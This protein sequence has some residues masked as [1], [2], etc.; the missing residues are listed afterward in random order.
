MHP[1][2]FLALPILGIFLVRAGFYTR[3]EAKIRLFKEARD[4][5]ILKN[6]S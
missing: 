6:R 5:L 4:Y 2:A 3:G 1:L